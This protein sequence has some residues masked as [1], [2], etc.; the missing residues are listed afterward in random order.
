M[1]L[2]L[3]ICILGLNISIKPIMLDTLI[4]GG[5]GHSAA[6]R[7]MDVVVRNFPEASSEQLEKIQTSL[8]NGEALKDMTGAYMD[9]A[10]KAVVENQTIPVVDMDDEIGSMTDEALE[11]ITSVVG[12]GMDSELRQ[13]LIKE[14]G[15]I[16]QAIFDYVQAVLSGFGRLRHLMTAYWLI[17]SNGCRIICSIGII[18]A[19][20]GLYLLKKRLLTVIGICKW[21]VLLSGICLG[22]L[23]P[24]TVTSVWPMVAN[25][26]LG[27]RGMEV[28]I[29]I[30][31]NT[32][33]LL[34]VI[35]IVFLIVSILD[36]RGSQSVE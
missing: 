4:K 31:R 1:I 23:A 6:V 30:L 28:N 17:S 26:F 32:G 8:E 11:I 33:V 2:F 9:S 19:L 5:V 27:G 16:S 36:K 12:G 13:Q 35:G 15:E 10:V 20:G 22:I 14:S 34:L 18:A 29:S 3:L 25:R 21:P 7:M 24:V